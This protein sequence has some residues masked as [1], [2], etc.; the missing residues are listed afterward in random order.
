MIIITRKEKII[1]E[2]I[3]DLKPEFIDGIP[4][5]IIKMKVDI[6]EHDYHE[7]LDNLQSK[8]LIIRENGKIKPQEVKDQIKVV[9]NK[10]E[11]KIE[12]LN[13]LEKEAIKIIK[14]LAEDGLIPRYTL[15]G[16][17]LYGK[18]KLDNLQMYRLLLSLEN[19][20]ILKKIKRKDGEY[21]K[22]L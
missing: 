15:E 18:L 10:K 4:E 11:V 17:L 6:S 20:K 7:I 21:Y 1:Y 3:K 8:N 14:K 2:E 19:K 5:K 9:E 13:Q 12:E 16:N 22:L